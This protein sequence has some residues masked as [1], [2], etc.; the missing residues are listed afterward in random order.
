MGRSRFSGG[1]IISAIKV[2]EPEVA[3]VDIYRRFGITP[4]SCYRWQKRSDA[5]A[6]LAS[7]QS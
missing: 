6:S 4:F 7:R 3:A 1:Q 2:V 5:K